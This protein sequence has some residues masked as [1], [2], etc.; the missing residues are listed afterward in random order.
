MINNNQITFALILL[1][2]GLVFAGGIYFYRLARYRKTLSRQVEHLLRLSE[3]NSR[4]IAIHESKYLFEAA[5]TM[6]QERL[7]YAHVAIFTINRER[8]GFELK[9]ISHSTPNPPEETPLLPLNKGL[10]G[11]VA[12]HNQS[13]LVNDVRSDARYYQSVSNQGSQ[14]ELIVPIQIRGGI[15]GVLDVQSAQLNAF[16]E[17]DLLVLKSL[18]NQVAVT[19]ERTRLYEAV[20]QELAERRQTEAALRESEAKYRELVKYAPAGIYEI[21]FVNNRFV[22]VNDVMCEYTGYTRQEFLAMSPLDI[23]TPVSR[24]RF[25]RRY[26]KIM[27][28][29]QVPEIAEYTIRG[30]NGYQRHVILNASF[31]Y[32]ADKITGAVVVAH[33][34]TARKVAEER[35]RAGE[36]RYRQAVENSPN[37]IFEVN[38]SG[39]I[40]TWNRASEEILHYGPEMIGQKVQTLLADPQDSARIETALEQ[41][42][43]GLSL[44]NFN[45]SFCTRHNIQRFMNSRLYPLF[46]HTGNVQACVFA[47]TDLTD[48]VQAEARIHKLNKEL[49]QRVKERTAQL[50]AA[51]KELEAFAYSVS[52]DLR[53]PLRRIRGFGRALLKDYTPLLDETGQ[54]Y[55]QRIDASGRRME[56]LIEGLLQLSR[57]T[58]GALQFAPV[59]L[60]EIAQ[61]IIT[62]L[63]KMEPERQVDFTCAPG[64]MTHGD[65]RLLRTMLENLL[66]NAWKFT[67]PRRPAEIEF[68]III[69]ENA[70]TY[71]IRDNGV[72]FDMRYTDKLF[73]AFQRLHSESEFEGTGIGLATVRRIVHRHGGHI[74]VESGVDEGTTFY[75]VL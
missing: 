66:K 61:E 59:N 27:S 32:A 22:S 74:W 10:M 9:A 11:W 43:R 35:V 20:Q 15:M 55:L 64:L 46:D 75:F 62:D 42:F 63:Q 1:L 70:P 68:G 19:L 16:D 33:D 56:Q 73:G 14:S 51:N 72:G 12:Q 37:P 13:L 45:I 25:L 53:A 29:T 40:Q 38:R 24:R 28:G 36:Q 26:A 48:R 65:K 54:D 18:A 30:K 6:A 71:F 67:R 31:Q 41:V 21:D 39:V 4:L 69:I 44:S 58:Q 3:I 47:N 50:Q 2:A 57:L 49:E 34:I 60:S 5:V 23:L 52:H 7:D 17:T 8:E